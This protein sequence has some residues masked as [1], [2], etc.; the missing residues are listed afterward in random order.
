MKKCIQASLLTLLAAA[1]LAPASPAG[2]LF[3]SGG[4]KKPA[5]PAAQPPQADASL[6]GMEGGSD[7]DLQ[8]EAQKAQA[9]PAAQPSG[10]APGAGDAAEPKVSES[11]TAVGTNPAQAASGAMPKEVEIKDA[12][13]KQ[14]SRKGKSTGDR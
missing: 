2:A 4:K 1:L 9:Q 14:K 13:G 5:A 3:G 11:E 12:T 10:Q 6:P 7:E 8:P